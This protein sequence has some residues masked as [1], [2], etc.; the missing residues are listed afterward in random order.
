MVGFVGPN[1]AGK[2]TAMRIVLGVLRPD[3]GQVRWREQRVDAEIRRRFGYMPEERGLYPKM[4]VLDQ[5]VYLARLHG[6]TADDARAQAARMVEVLGVPE[7]VKDKTESLSLGN[8]QRVQLAAALVHRPEVL[9]LDEPFSGLDP[10]GVDV[11]SGVLREQAEAGVPVVFSS[12]QLDLVERLCESVVLIDRGRVVAD[13]RIADLRARDPR[14]LVRIEVPRG[15]RRMARRAP[16]GPHPRAAPGW[17][18]PRARRRRPRDRRARRRESGGRGAALQRRAAEPVGDLP[19]GGD[20]VSPWRIVARREFVE[21]ARDRGF[22]ISTVITLLI[23]VGIIVITNA[24]DRGTTFDVVVVGEGSASLAEDVTTAASVLGVGVDVGTLPDGEAAER[25]VRCGR[26]GRRDHRRGPDPRAGRTP[27]AARR[28]D[29]GGLDPAALAGGA[30]R[31]RAV[32]GADPLR[33]H[34]AATARGRARAR[35]PA[36]AGARGRRVRRG[37]D[38]VR[39]AVRLRLLGRRGRRRGEELARDRGA[40]RDRPPLAAVA[41][42]DLRDRGARA[43]TAGGDRPR[44]P[45]DVVRRRPARVP[46]GGARD[47]RAR[48]V[49]VRPGLLLLR[50]V[51]RRRGVHRDPTGGPPV[52]DDAAHDLDRGVVLHRDQRDVGT[53]APRSRPSPRCCRSRLRS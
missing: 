35:G 50:G 25:A 9:V 30:G 53:R 21:R 47:R 52:D 10:V 11:L 34:P 37:A 14:R 45:G 7:R 39:A 32:R 36:A 16:G 28:A 42:E 22:L 46:V 17:G 6:L 33:P 38:P 40:P 4:R 5:L 3:A 43:R 20:A 29:P 51:V 15:R 44:G 26:G 41:R 49:L 18:D 12:H 2:T 27:G 19:R 23:L 31:G 1:G 8:Q 13:G 48:A 24:L